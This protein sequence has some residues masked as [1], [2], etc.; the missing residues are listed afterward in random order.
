MFKKL[1]PLM[2]L[3]ALLSVVLVACGDS[4]TTVDLPSYSGAKTLTMTDAAKKGLNVDDVSKK[5]GKIEAF[6]T[7]D[8]ATKVKSFYADELT[9]KGWSEDKNLLSSDEMQSLGSIEKVG[10]FALIFSKGDQAVMYL[11][12][13]GVAGSALGFS[14]VGQ[15]DTLVIVASGS[16][17]S[18]RSK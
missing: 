15:K 6:S 18:I 2:V 1:I 3:A 11:G 5:G 14:E 16:K 4:A 13:P 8:E 10:G 9:K 17:D 12:V 7:T